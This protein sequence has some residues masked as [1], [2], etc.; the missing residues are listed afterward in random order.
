MVAVQVG[1]ERR[2]ALGAAFGTTDAD[3]R[4]VTVDDA[5]AA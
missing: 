4:A 2:R 1:R 5:L 3:R